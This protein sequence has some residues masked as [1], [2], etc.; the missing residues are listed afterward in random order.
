MCLL[1]IVVVSLPRL[2][3][4]D[5]A[6]EAGRLWLF[7]LFIWLLFIVS[8]QLAFLAFLVYATAV[9]G[10]DETASVV[11]RIRGI[12]F[13]VPPNNLAFAI[14]WMIIGATCLTSPAL[15]AVCVYFSRIYPGHRAVHLACCSCTCLGPTQDFVDS[16]INRDVEEGKQG[17]FVSA[18]PPAIIKVE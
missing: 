16:Y 15:I 11:V 4:T 5:L 12:T 17:I 2:K 14:P 18:C 7:L 3:C 10:L 13:L 8:V 9:Y 6:Y 1:L